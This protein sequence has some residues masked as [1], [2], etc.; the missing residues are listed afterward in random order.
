LVTK[1]TFPPRPPVAFLPNPSARG[2]AKASSCTCVG[3][4]K[5]VVGLEDVL[6]EYEVVVFL[7]EAQEKSPKLRKKRKE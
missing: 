1:I 2:K 6:L 7:Q 3:L 5:D 4:S